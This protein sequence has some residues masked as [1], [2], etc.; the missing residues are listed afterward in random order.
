MVFREFYRAIPVGGREPMTDSVAAE[1]MTAMCLMPFMVTDFRL[2]VSPMVTASD[3]SQS[4]MAVVRTQG[5]TQEGATALEELKN[6]ELSP[7]S[8]KIG[9]VELFG[10]IG[11]ARRAL[12]LLQ[13]EPA[14]HVYVDNSPE[15]TRVVAI[16]WP[17]SVRHSMVEDITEEDVKAWVAAGPHIAVW[18]LVA[19]F[20]CQ[21]L[22]A[23]N[24]QRSNHRDAKT[25]LCFEIGR[26]RSMLEK[27]SGKRVFAAREN[28]SSMDEEMVKFFNEE[29]EAIPYKVCPSD[30]CHVRRPRLFWLDWKLGRY[31]DVQFE[32]RGLT[33]KVVFQGL[34]SHSSGWL[35]DGWE[36]YGGEDNVLPTFV[37]PHEH[38]QEPYP[39]AGKERCNEEALKRWQSDRWRYPPYQYQLTAGLV[40]KKEGK[41]RYPDP[42]EKELL[43]K[44]RA[45]HTLP[46]APAIFEKDHPE[47]FDNLRG[48]LL[49]NSFHCGVLAYLLSDLL[50]QVGLKKQ[51]PS[52]AVIATRTPMQAES[53][54]QRGKHARLKASEVQEGKHKAMTQ[55]E[56]MVREL[57]RRQVH[58]G[59][60]IRSTGLL[61]LPLRWPRNHVPTNWWIWKPVLDTRV[62]FEE[63]IN[64]LEVRSDLLALRWRL[65]VAGNVGC[66]TLQLMDSQVSLGAI[67]KGRSPSAALAP[68]VEKI[69][70]LSIAGS[71]VQHVAYTTTNQNPADAG[72]RRHDEE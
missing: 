46:C 13:V 34:R 18:I 1:L 5:L 60:D 69:G 22:T 57:I 11:G 7:S 38:H 23:L 19:G 65:R 9:L 63:H 72:S 26:I 51:R 20:P 16:A 15:A 25:Q 12:E 17:E 8:D 43:L 2:L 50:F 71:T 47:A 45:E 6:A 32:D 35:K 56:E 66:H 59:A 36:L 67:P 31:N 42:E 40:S 39:A 28:V 27:F 58:R 33:Q 24:S 48:K 4:G 37:A 53:A 3:A 44:F 29:F 14:V 10:G 68:V 41:W 49:G 70:A 21:G 62:E 55:E 64:V 30:L 54:T 52:T 61:G